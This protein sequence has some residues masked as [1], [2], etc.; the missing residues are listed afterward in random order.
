MTSQEEMVQPDI[1]Q[2]TEKTMNH[3]QMYIFTWQP[4]QGPAR[5]EGQA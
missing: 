2:T 4:G 1:P 5:H 3:L